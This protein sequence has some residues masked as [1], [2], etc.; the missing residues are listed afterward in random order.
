MKKKWNI[1]IL[2]MF[3]LL[4]SSL[5]G[6]LTINFVQQMM[7]NSNYILSYYKSYYI[8]K[9]WIELAL[10]EISSRW[11]WF[12]FSTN[13]WDAIISSNFSCY[14][15][16][17]F[18]SN[19]IWKSSHLS[20]KFQQWTG[21]QNPFILNSGDSLIL[22]LFKENTLETHFDI[23]DS[24]IEYTNFSSNIRNLSI[25][26]TGLDQKISLWFMITSWSSL[27]QEIYSN[28]IFFKKWTLTDTFIQDFF[29]QFENYRSW[30]SNDDPHLSDANIFLSQDANNY[31]NYFIISN[32]QSD[33]ISFCL[34]IPI[35]PNQVEN[36]LPTNNF[37]IKSVWDYWNQIIW[38][39]AF[40]KQPIPDF[41]LNTYLNY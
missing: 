11:I 26:T 25:Q 4:A 38:L 23:F 14:P 35:N 15:N 1:S 19:I 17:N 9:A 31:K 5:I 18:Y 37:Y 3:V 8:T 21:C 7:K 6:V 32:I 24:P 10:T 41:L 29:T 2:V 40:Y 36:F 34:D 27:S 12:E 22:P 16:C 33:S 30:L 13:T 39:E 28:W 20:Q